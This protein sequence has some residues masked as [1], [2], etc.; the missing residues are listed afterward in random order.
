MQPEDL[1]PTLDPIP[2][3]QPQEPQQDGLLV[4]KPSAPLAADP[5]EKEPEAEVAPAL[6]LEPQDPE[7]QDP[8]MDAMRRRRQERE[9]E[10]EDAFMRVWD[11]AIRGP[12]SADVIAEAQ[13]IGKELNLPED[14]VLRNP[15]VA[16]RI[17][18]TRQAEKLE[19]AKQYPALA[20]T[21]SDSPPFARIAKDRLEN[22]TKIEESVQWYEGLEPLWLRPSR[23]PARARELKRMFTEEGYFG[24][25][26]EKAKALNEIELEKQRLGHLWQTSGE[27]RPLEVARL[28]QLERDAEALGP[29][30]SFG[31]AASSM[32][33]LLPAFERGAGVAAGAATT[34]GVAT[35]AAGPAAPAA[36]ITAG[37]AAAVGF[38]VGMT[39]VLFEQYTRTDLAEMVNR[40]VPIEDARF[41]APLSGAI[42][43]ALDT[44][45]PVAGGQ[46]RRELTRSAG[47]EVIERLVRELATPM[48]SGRAVREFAWTYGKDTAFETVQEVA[49]DITSTL[50]INLADKKTQLSR[51]E[52]VGQLLETVKQ[53][54]MVSAWMTP[55]GPSVRLF[56]D[57]RRAARGTNGSRLIEDLHDNTVREQVRLRNPELFAQYM[58]AVTN[59][60]GAESL[61]I[62]V[63]QLAGAWNSLVNRTMEQGRTAAEGTAEVLPDRER[64]SASMLEEVR[65]RAPEMAAAIE[66]SLRVGP[67]TESHVKI[68]TSQYYTYLNAMPIGDAIRPHL[69]FDPS[70]M[71]AAE[72]QQHNAQRQKLVDEAKKA[73]EARK[74]DR[75]TWAG[76]ARDVYNLVLRK[77]RGTNAFGNDAARK[78]SA[79][80]LQAMIVTMAANETKAGKPTTPMQA[81]RN[82]KWGR[83]EVEIAQPADGKAPYPTAV[84]ELQML[85]EEQ[86]GMLSEIDALEPLRVQAEAPEA[87]QEIKDEYDAKKI[88]LEARMADLAERQ[89]LAQRRAVEERELEAA[90]IPKVPSHLRSDQPYDE[91]VEPPQDGRVFEKDRKEYGS[92]VPPEQVRMTEGQKK[93]LAAM[94]KADPKLKAL[95]EHLREDELAALVRAGGDD[96]ATRA[97]QLRKIMEQMP[98]AT[99]MAAVAKAGIAKKGWYKLS[100]AAISRVFGADAR[101]FAALLAAL[102]PQTSVEANLANALRV[103]RAWIKAG[104]P[105]SES[106]ILAIM[107]ANVQG[108]KGEKSVLGA[109]KNNAY[110]ALIMDNPERIVLSGP[111]VN[112]FMLNLLD[113]VVAYTEEVTNDAWMSNYSG[114][115]QEEFGADKG[116]GM[117]GKGVGYLAMSLQS[118]RA[119]RQLEWEGR[120]IQETVWSF[121][122]ALYEKVTKLLKNGE[123][124]TAESLITSGGLLHEDIAATPDFEKLFV[125]PTYRQFFDEQAYGAVLD[126]LAVEVAKRQETALTGSVYTGTPEELEHMRRAAKRLDALREYRKW[127]ETRSDVLINLSAATPDIP[128][129]AKL[130]REANA[131]NQESQ[132]LLQE[133]A[134]EAL[135]YLM[136]NVTSAEIS[137]SR[138]TGL[139]A[140]GLEPSL[141][142]AISFTNADRP[143]ALVALK[144]FARMFDQKQVHLRQA[145]DGRFGTQNPD[146]SYN[147]KAYKIYLNKPMARADVEKLARESGLSGFTVEDNALEVYFVGDPKDAT[148]RQEFQDAAEAAVK[149]LRA[150]GA[151]RRGGDGVRGGYEA[152]VQRLWAYGSGPGATAGYD[153]IPGKFSPPRD[154][155]ASRAAQRV[156]TRLAGREVMGSPQAP[157]IT[158]DQRE[159]QRRIAAA[160]EAMRLNALDDPH[161]RRAYEELAVELLEQFDALPIR[162]E[163]FADVYGLPAGTTTEQVQEAAKALGI[164]VK[165]HAAGVEIEYRPPGD[166]WETGQ[167]GPLD[168]DAAAKHKSAFN[169]SVTKLRKQIKATAETVRGTPAPGE[170]RLYVF[171]KKGEPYPSKKMSAEMRQDVLSENHMWV[172][173]TIP[174]QFG[175]PGVDYTGHPLLADSGRTDM[176]G[177]PLVMN[178]L[179]RAVHDYYAH[180]LTTVGFGPLGEEAAWRNHMEMTRSPWAR[181]A[182]TTET[183]GQN[184]W[185]N[186]REGVEGKP[187][188]ERGFADQKADLL[189]IEYIVT[190][191]P[192]ID[193]SL[194]SLPGAEVLNLEGPPATL[195]QM[196][197]MQPEETRELNA[198]RFDEE[199]NVLPA[200]VQD[201]NGNELNMVAVHSLDMAY[202]ADALEQGSVPMPSVA[203]TKFDKAVPAFGNVTLVGKRSLVD[204]ERGARTFDFDIFSETYPQTS[205]EP[206]ADPDAVYNAILR[207]GDK[208][209]AMMPADEQKVYDDY[210]SGEPVAAP[211]DRAQL[212][213]NVGVAYGFASD[214]SLRMSLDEST[215]GAR[216]SIKR[217]LQGRGMW[218]LWLSELGIPVEMSRFASERDRQVRKAQQEAMQKFGWDE[219]KLQAEFNKFHEKKMAE[220]GLVPEKRMVLVGG[221]LVPATNANVV[222]AMVERNPNIV[223]M[224][225]GYSR[226]QFAREFKS[227]ADMQRERERLQGTGSIDPSTRATWQLL[228]DEAQVLISKLRTGIGNAIR[229]HPDYTTAWMNADQE[230]KDIISALVG[231]RIGG[232]YDQKLASSLIDS[233]R[234]ALFAMRDIYGMDPLQLAE[235]FNSENL[236]NI[237][238]FYDKLLQAM[239]KAI[240][241]LE[242]ENGVIKDPYFAEKIRNL[243]VSVR[244]ILVT[245]LR[246]VQPYWESKTP[247]EAP[248]SDF[249]GAVVPSTMDPEQRLALQRAG[250]VVKVLGEREQN[251]MDLVRDIA[252]ETHTDEEPVLFAEGAEGDGGPQRR[253]KINLDTYKITLDP[254]ATV[255]AWFHELT[256]GYQQ[257]L[258][259]MARDPNASPWVLE[260]LTTLFDWFKIGTPEQSMAERL[261]Q[262]D[263]L[264]FKGQEPYWEQL[265]YNSELYVATG[266]APTTALERVFQSVRNFVRTMYKQISTSL[267]NTYRRLFNKDLPGLTPEVRGFFD[268]ML[269]TEEQIQQAQWAN[270]MVPMFTS[271]EGAPMTAEQLAEYQALDREATEEAITEMD[272]IR[273]NEMRLLRKAPGRALAEVHRLAREVRAGIYAE[274]YQ[275]MRRQPIYR[276]MHYLRTGELIQPDGTTQPAT[277]N[278]KLDLARV[279]ALFP[280]AMGQKQQAEA[281][282]RMGVGK[283]GMLRRNG[284]HPDDA[285]DLFGFVSGEQMV[286]DLANAPE[287]EEAVE[288]ETDRRAKEE[289]GE[290]FT[291]E[292]MENALVQVLNNKARTRFIAS[293]LRWLDK[294]ARTAAEHIEVAREAARQIL[295]GKSIRDIKPREFKALEADARRASVR[296]WKKGDAQAAIVAKRRELLYHEMAKQAVAI[297]ERVAAAK[298]MWA[299]LFRPDA[300]IAKTRMLDLV[301][302]ARS[303][304][305][306]HGF[307]RAKQEPAKYLELMAKYSKST[308]EEMLPLFV[309]AQENPTNYKDLSLEDFDGLHDAV[310]ALWNM[311]KRKKQI[312]VEGKLVDVATAVEPLNGRMQELGVPAPGKAPGE[313]MAPSPMQ[314]AMRQLMV[315]RALLRRIGAWARAMDGA[316]DGPFTRYIYRPIRMAWDAYKQARISYLFKVREIIAAVD[317]VRGKISADEFNYVFG[318]GN[319]G[320]GIAELLGAMQHMGNPQNLRNNLVGRK[321]ATVNPDGSIDTSRW[322]SFIHRMVREG[323]VTKQHLDALQRLWDVY[324]ELLP[325][326][327][328][329][330]YDRNGY[331]MKEVKAEAFTVTFPDGQTVTYRGGY[332]PAKMDSWLVPDAMAFEELDVLDGDFRQQVAKGN[333]G[334]TKQRVKKNERPLNLDIR[335]ILKH[336]D[337][338]LRYVH[339]QGAISDVQSIIKS[340]EFAATAD[341]LDPSMRPMLMHWL[342]GTAHAI[343]TRPGLLPAIDRFWNAVRKRVT[344]NTMFAAVRNI[345]QQFT[346]WFPALVA[347]NTDMKPA[348]NASFLESTMFALRKLLV[349]ARYLY[350]GFAQ[351]IGN[352][353][354]I[355]RFIQENSLYMRERM[356]N[357]TMDLTSEIND[358]VL[359]PS[360]YNK[361]QKFWEK[362]ALIG[363]QMTQTMVDAVTWMAAYNAAMDTLPRDMDEKAMMKEAS[364]R[365][366]EAVRLSQSSS[367]APD[368]AE[369]QRSS[370]FFAMITHFSGYFNAMANLQATE[371][372]RT[373][374]EMGFGPRAAPQLVLAFAMAQFLP[375][376]IGDGIS[377][378]LGGQLA[379]D[380][381]DGYWDEVLAWLFGSQISGA[382]A[383]IPAIGPSVVAG[384]NAFNDK[385]Y[386]DRMMTAPSISNLESAARG[387]ALPYKVFTKDEIKGRDVRDVF[388]LIALLTGYPVGVVGRGA[389]Y[390]VDVERGA[391]QPYGTGDYVRGLMT[392]QPAAGTR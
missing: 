318:N 286:M 128:G 132:V 24:E 201:E 233:Y 351:W 146:G 59:G 204:P 54:A 216:E 166:I 263:A 169:R 323:K 74:E 103:W 200:E 138:T 328:Q 376:L 372:V 220:Y 329:V 38:T 267:N 95:I 189:P 140:G 37:A 176:N 348:P 6:S 325:Q 116:A 40:G 100:A 369:Y 254:E 252:M 212:L 211:P 93:A 70:M 367:E 151:I 119:A 273:V 275:R 224:T 297:R 162:V 304:L 259:E 336:M 210:E 213:G 49:Q 246:D 9:R 326:I 268:R 242:I 277:V 46:I 300:K 19:L 180:S 1:D 112:S 184:S 99:E 62:N 255:S 226:S 352:P 68:S 98:S 228:E 219:T 301:D 4:A 29:V 338:V 117:P 247:R 137:V 356:L 292:A 142:L 391:V 271:L 274:V 382:A 143:A 64:V 344:A 197:A 303:L 153:A 16:K 280:K 218:A 298:K 203:I 106:A 264:G 133:I 196:R 381:G 87:T 202:I 295:A 56:S 160:Y 282:R 342:V 266:K 10:P 22:L 350:G 357:Q 371:Y 82:S 101:R 269:A 378:A 334:F 7:K 209:I 94:V 73:L 392:G 260:Q 229:N 174:E 33:F 390:A 290:L 168:P 121:S 157:G 41:W 227:I 207:D 231:Q 129:L 90:K 389:G 17:Y 148:K 51:E 179:L 194:A 3:Q 276:L 307:E 75:D 26:W 296:A 330:H 289:Y 139:H 281:L 109:W 363:Q 370:P 171:A 353:R 249:V 333:D 310:M 386:D 183:R 244:K 21:I 76:E 360:R 388:T 251:R 265:A 178:D 253:A 384:F 232:G 187:L 144:Q 299:K 154:D 284:M 127:L 114:I 108:D 182:L 354:K 122:K 150:A 319:G 221:M 156:A 167:E 235:T 83:L 185:V 361:G 177:R 130:T 261:Q 66:T 345:L 349:N 175:K 84:E 115:A 57:L 69:K 136:H 96:A 302:V 346:G 343:T 53:S 192:E 317:L 141:G 42:Q 243:S 44:A 385:P 205:I 283:G 149:S 92:T 81:F 195:E 85:S 111:K 225:T 387:A 308:L 223:S 173:A 158:Q 102:S 245:L 368:V 8:F 97:E 135:R 206:L 88:N 291:P 217:R 32:L 193:A 311:A 2:Q 294:A 36:P 335:L 250:L 172:Y 313:A 55:M 288:V 86:A 181:W 123:K 80:L 373:I 107:G 27:V 161:V 63:E 332:V 327:Q 322:W 170:L 312:R 383:T 126:G 190:G 293:E 145:T 12:D 287:L 28:Q 120:E 324:E 39:Q 89:G 279:K 337:D 236:Q 124:V 165:V 237:G 34:V 230:T 358:L 359:N 380:E 306:A 23:I 48:T 147:T 65:K 72:V 305:A 78:Q 321:W 163:L 222:K 199:G 331:R 240:P 186:F 278:V 77:L 314:R 13:R 341:R 347:F 71:S 191:N 15:D 159:W 110:R 58:D 309:R 91:D 241:T 131:G 256:H 340:Q 118:R 152:H 125:D 43:A 18:Q 188:V 198:M 239:Q 339:V 61:Y 316:E 285:A 105:T 366:D 375:T 315:G 379:D 104:R 52:L 257:M 377:R 208:V 50:F 215:N 11:A 60:T 364:W 20:Q 67:P 272:R 14:T 155:V 30:S 365:A 234:D 362:H 355:N 214:T 113:D 45:A 164:P 31:Q 258:V 374:R 5:Q 270:D 79:E 25:G 262:W 134:N 35:L 238:P 248:L 47:K 320:I